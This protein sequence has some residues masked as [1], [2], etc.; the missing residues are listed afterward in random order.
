M[1]V[2]SAIS[3][4]VVLF[5]STDNLLALLKRF[6]KCKISSHSCCILSGNN[7]GVLLGTLSLKLIVLLNFT[8]LVLANLY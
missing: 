2:N 1:C 8:N 4:N 5:G 3:T 7:K 6:N